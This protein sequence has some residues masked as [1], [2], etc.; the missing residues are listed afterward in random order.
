MLGDITN[1]ILETYRP[2]AI[3][4]HGSRARGKERQ[5]SDWDIILLYNG[6]TDIKNGRELYKE[7]NIEYSVH[8]LPIEDIF[9]QFGTKLQG[10]T[11]LCEQGNIASTLLK[12]AADYYAQGVRW[13]PEKIV[14]HKLWLQGRINGMKDN[15]DNPIIFEKYFTDFY[16]RIFDY[17]Y[18]LLQN[19]HSQP[20]YVAVEEIA[21]IDRDYYE[22]LSK[23]IDSTILIE[24][25]AIAEEIGA[26]LFGND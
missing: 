5:H 16:N 18:W 22:L 10:A 9:E 6:P 23:L 25:V 26:R 7:Q 20:I 13:S 19:K 14:A 24:K 4:L 1:H 11:V 15:V 12:Q 2:D 3:I 8:S 17:W 21:T